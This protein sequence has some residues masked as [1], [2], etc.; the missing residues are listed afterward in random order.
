MNKRIL[1]SIVFVISV[2]LMISGLNAREHE[3]ED[4]RPK[5][6]S[7]DAQ[8]TKEQTVD[9]DAQQNTDIKTESQITQQPQLV[10]QT[11]EQINW[12][13]I[14]SGGSIGSS[15]NFTLAGTVGQITVGFGSSANYQVNSGFWQVFTSGSGCCIGATGD[16]NGSGVF[17]ISDLLY[18][19]DYLFIPASPGPPCSEEADFDINA[20]VDIS[21][22]LYLVDYM[23]IPGS[24]GLP[25][26]P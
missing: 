19:V 15:A 26:C 22:L 1:T 6:K 4:R 10:P 20:A 2:S 21:D 13:V 7:H 14:A 11:G 23:F 8:I 12:Q 9:A 18:L 5:N 16:V 25:D 17:D 24:P 3:D